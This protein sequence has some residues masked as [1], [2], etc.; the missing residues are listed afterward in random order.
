MSVVAFTKVEHLLLA[1]DLTDGTNVSEFFRKFISRADWPLDNY[2]LWVDECLGKSSKKEPNYSNA[3]QDLVVILGQRLGL[4][5]DFGRYKGSTGG[6][7]DYDGLWETS[8][9]NYVVVEV[10][11]SDVF[12][13]KV[14]QVGGYMK[15]VAQKKGVEINDVFGLYIIGKIKD[16]QPL[17][18]QIKGSEFRN[19]IRI[20]TVDCLFDLLE[21]GEKLS[22][23]AESETITKSIQNIIMPLDPV[24]VD[25]SVN[26]IKDLAGLMMSESEGSIS[27]VVKPKVIDKEKPK[28]EEK[29]P[30]KERRFK[31][32]EIVKAGIA[33]K[34]TLVFTK[35]KGETYTAEITENGMLYREKIYDSPST[36]GRQVK[37]YACDG[38]FFW[39][40][41]EEGKSQPISI[42]RER[43]L[44]K[45]K[46]G[47]ESL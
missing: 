19:S 8:D 43:L 17:A 45:E 30:V 14:D 24:L 10:K 27:K 37:G 1:G 42:W 16:P 3:F 26:I 35:Y 29:K 4:E 15:A 2:K 28:P 44:E 31:I 7:I 22:S 25:R 36:A 20:V 9:H 33:Q 13:H 5:V 18:N 39:K 23:K 11:T 38:W 40:F 6:E 12:S 32:S 46:R 41:E 47:N 34:G 21:L